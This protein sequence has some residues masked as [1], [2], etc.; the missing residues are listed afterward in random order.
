MGEEKPGRSRRGLVPKPEYAAVRIASP[1]D[2][3]AI[4]AVAHATWH[5]TYAEL[6]SE[7]TINA[8]LKRAYSDYALRQTLNDGGLWV[9]ERSGG[10]GGY[11]RLG[12]Q[13]AVGQLNAIYVHPDLQGRGYGYRLWRCAEVWFAARGIR[14]VQLT[15]ADANAQAR[16]FYRRLGF[17]ER[18]ER[19]SRLHGEPLV[20]RVCTLTLAERD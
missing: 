19:R 7:A 14:E 6:L 13:D 9:L 8:F 18:G 3:D 15:V 4:Q 5:A 16:A 17:V 2:I 20:E 12:V 1:A 10:I 11:V